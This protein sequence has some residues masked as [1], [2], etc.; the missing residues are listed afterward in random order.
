[1]MASGNDQLSYS[2]DEQKEDEQHAERENV[3]RAV[4]GEFLL[5][6]HLGP[7]RRKAGGQNFFGESFDRGERVARART[8][9]GL[10]AQVGGGKH[11]VARD[12]V[13][14]AHFLHGRDRPERNNPAL[15]IARL[16]QADVF[17][18]Q[19]ELRVGLSRHAIGAA[20]EGEV[21]HV[22]R[23]EISL[24]RAEDVAERHI[25]ALRFDAIHFEPELRHVGAKCRE[26]V[27]NSGRLVCFHHHGES[28]RL[29]FFEAGV[30]AI[31]NEKAIAAGVANPGHRRRRKDRDECFRNLG[32][33]AR[34]HLC[35]DRWHFL[36]GGVSLRE[37]LEWQEDRSGVGLIA[38]EKVEAGD[39]NGVEHAGRFAPDLRDL[40]DDGLGAIERR[41]VGQ[42]C[43]ND[44]V[45]AILRRE[46]TA[47]HNFE[48]ETG[49]GK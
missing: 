18:I 43:V 34:V 21:V 29:Q 38:A 6:R 10:A 8:R 23:T 19:A 48:T 41:R 5:E 1:M 35:Q 4:A 22:G 47:R 25:H 3:D 2:A 12:L 31:L 30:A 9:C 14:A 44:G 24:E 26:V 15:S 46:K 27:R 28:L 37:F 40:I 39:L 45:A 20:E 13:G 49:Q 42:L 36:L 16:E 17:G 32:A 33:N 11:V 7:F